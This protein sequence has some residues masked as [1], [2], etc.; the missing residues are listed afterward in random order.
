MHNKYGV[1]LN[2]KE[3]RIK[4]LNDVKLNNRLINKHLEYCPFQILL[5]YLIVW[6]T[7][8]FNM[9]D[10]AINSFI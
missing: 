1:K 10:K 8:D 5:F 9:Y 6:K 3:K 7:L 2:N 4:K